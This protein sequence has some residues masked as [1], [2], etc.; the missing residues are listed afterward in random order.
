MVGVGSSWVRRRGRLLPFRRRAVS[1]LGPELPRRRRGA[2]RQRLAALQMVR[3]HSKRIRTLAREHAVA[4]EAIAG[5]I[6]W[7]A[8]ENPYLRT[9]LRLGPGKIRPFRPWGPSDA[10]RAERARLLPYRPR[11]GFAR[12]QLLRRPEAAIAYT[13]AILALYAADY[14]RI[15]GV[16]IGGDPAVL[17]TLW[18]GGE[19]VERARRLAR[20]RANDPAAS[21]R[22]ADEMGPWVGRHAGF[23]RSVLDP[24]AQPQPDPSPK[25]G[26]AAPLRS[27]S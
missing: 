13:A 1:G 27:S 8:L 14:R 26:S 22:G 19:S 24:A 18:Q 2:E 6:L 3:A 20:R 7:D 11:N 25:P 9:F 5:A 10:E 21:P 15:A 17:C 12:L 16:E 4:E 23:I